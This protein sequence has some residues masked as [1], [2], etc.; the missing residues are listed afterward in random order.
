MKKSIVTIAIAAI[1]LTSTSIG[2]ANN[3][4]K[5]V[6]AQEEIVEAKE[7]V[8]EAK[9]ELATAQENA[10]ISAAK[11]A[12]VEEWKLFKI[13]SE[14]KIQNNEAAIARLKMSLK[15][16]GVALEASYKER[17]DILE[18]R[19]QDI[20]A[21]VNDYETSQS[22]WASFKRAYDADMEVIS[23]AIIDMGANNRK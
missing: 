22:D 17:I 21:K 16:P 4:E 1:A 11:A 10:A 3:A 19:N 13:E 12:T 7:E 6:D 23:K 15:K 9:D 14:T 5:L 18:K 8:V 2:C 20:K